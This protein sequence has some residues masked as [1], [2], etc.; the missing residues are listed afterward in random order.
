MSETGKGKR[1]SRKRGLQAQLDDLATAELPVARATAELLVTSGPNVIPQLVA[2]LPKV[3]LERRLL[4]SDLLARICSRDNHAVELV[5]EILTKPGGP[6]HRKWLASCLASV[7]L[8]EQALKK[9]LH[10]TRSKNRWV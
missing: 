2:L 6:P 4:I 8:P 9:I 7:P 1:K 10:A 3:P 5:V